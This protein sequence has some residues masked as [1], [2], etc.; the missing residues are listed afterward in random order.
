MFEYILKKPTKIVKNLL[1]QIENH[2]KGN[3]TYINIF[4]MCYEVFILFQCCSK[5]PKNK[6]EK[7]IKYE[8]L[9]D[10]HFMIKKEPERKKYYNLGLSKNKIIQIYYIS[11]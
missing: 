11:K 2:I 7:I 4:C 8:N 1:I 9:Y 6:I 5:F 3:T 10:M